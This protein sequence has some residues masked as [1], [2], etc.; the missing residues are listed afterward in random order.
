MFKSA[1][2]NNVVTA[3]VVVYDEAKNHGDTLSES[4]FELKISEFSLDKLFSK[5]RAINERR[6]QQGLSLLVLAIPLS[7]CGG[8]DSTPATEVTGRAI[9][10]Y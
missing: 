7:A 10:G 5:F 6:V 2:N 1:I 4:G 3:N 9:D 8:S